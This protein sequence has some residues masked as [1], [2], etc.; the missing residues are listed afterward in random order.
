[1]VKSQASPLLAASPTPVEPVFDHETLQALVPGRAS[2]FP[3]PWPDGRPDPSDRER[4]H[5]GRLV[6]TLYWRDRRGGPWEVP[7]HLEHVPLTIPGNSG[8]T[9]AARWFPFQ[10]TNLISMDDEMKSGSGTTAADTS[11]APRRRPRGTVVLAHPDKRYGQ[12]WFVRHGWIDFLLQN[13]YQVL[14]FDFAIFG[15]S[16]DGQTYLAE[17][18][19]AAIRTAQ[20]ISD[21]TTPGTPLHAIGVSVGSFAMAHASACVPEL[22][23][24]LLE[25]PYPDF[26]S[27]YQRGPGKWSMDLFDRLVPRTSR[28]IRTEHNLPH[29]EADRILIVATEDD[30]VTPVRLSRAV[31]AHAPSERTRTHVFTDGAHLE[32]FETKPEYRALVLDHLA[33]P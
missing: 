17:D 4:R 33:G 32:L 7:Q 29:A 9:L 20:A 25:S 26:N 13:G 19:Y 30:Q 21:A 11:D 22:E 28:F 31:A 6:K 12:H 1:M 3:L 18:A 23:S 14:T 15:G 27:W 8:A 24:L 10:P 16:R 2:L 5:V